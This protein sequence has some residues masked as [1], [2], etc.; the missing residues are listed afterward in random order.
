MSL[1]EFAIILMHWVFAKQEGINQAHDVW[2]HM[3]QNF[4]IILPPPEQAIIGSG[5]IYLYVLFV[6]KLS[7]S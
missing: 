5:K 6:D 2:I 1:E 7:I 3:R 4:S